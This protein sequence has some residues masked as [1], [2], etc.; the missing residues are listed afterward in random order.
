MEIGGSN[1]GG[2]VLRRVEVAASR[3]LARAGVIVDYA[4]YPVRRDFTTTLSIEDAFLHQ[5]IDKI[6]QLTGDPSRTDRWVE[7]VGLNDTALSRSS[8]QEYAKSLKV[9]PI[10]ALG[11]AIIFPA[12]RV[13]SWG[14]HNVGKALQIIETLAVK[15]GLSGLLSKAGV[16]NIGAGANAAASAGTIASTGVEAINPAGRDFQPTPAIQQMIRS[17]AYARELSQRESMRA[18]AEAPGS[19]GSKVKKVIVVNLENHTDA[20]MFSQLRGTDQRLFT[21]LDVP[22]FTFAWWPTHGKFSAR[23]SKW[24]NVHERYDRSQAPMHFQDAASFALVKSRAPANTASTPNHIALFAGWFHNMLN[25]YYNGIIG[26]VVSIF[27]RQPEKPPFDI[28]SM[29]AHLEAAGR[30]WGIYGD[31]SAHDISSLRNSPSVVPTQQFFADAAAG[32]LRDVSWLVPPNSEDEHAPHAV[33]DGQAFVAQVKNALVASGEWEHTVIAVTYDD[34][35]GFADLSPN[36][37]VE[38]WTHDPRYQSAYGLSLPLTLIGAY[39]KPGYYRQDPGPAPGEHTSH[40]SI[41]GLIAAV[42]GLGEIDWHD[43]RPQWARHG[44]DDLTRA[45]DINQA[46]LPAPRPWQP[47]PAPKDSVLLRFAAAWKQAGKVQDLSDLRSLYRF[48][49]GFHE[50]VTRRVMADRGA[51]LGL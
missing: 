6:A 36:D 45:F 38:Q 51:A 24:M 49:L 17:G 33:W 34:S 11:A 23:R 4:T 20:N 46:P 42:T 37:A 12:V 7:A 14:S 3:I 27:A 28:D 18:L 50:A 13:L 22:D 47:A 15:L 1:S 31:G 43:E 29:P 10:T 5:G 41:N 39:V 40:L 21:A 32:K 48:D 2:D 44:I 25:N 26:T 35:G 9:L 30:T 16:G 19:I 8:H